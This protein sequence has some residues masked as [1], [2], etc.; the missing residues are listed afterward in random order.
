[1]PI[2]QLKFDFGCGAA[3]AMPTPVTKAILILH[4][5]ASQLDATD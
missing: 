5:A 4:D 1:M 2:D 3:T